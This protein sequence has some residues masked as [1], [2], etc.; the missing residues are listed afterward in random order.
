MCAGSSPSVPRTVICASLTGRELAPPA[1]R[2][3]AAPSGPP[4]ACAARRR[5][6]PCRRRRRAAPRARGPTSC[7]LRAVDLALQRAEHEVRGVDALLG[8]VVQLPRDPL[9]L[10][11]H[12][13]ALGAQA[14]VAQALEHVRR[15]RQRQHD[16]E[17]DHEVRGDRLQPDRALQRVRVQLG[18]DRDAEV[19]QRERQAPT[20]RAA[21]RLAGRRQDQRGEHED[22]ERA[23]PV[24]GRRDERERERAVDEPRRRRELQARHRR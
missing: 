23:A 7:D 16:D 3:S 6:C 22:V 4:A 11:L 9:A 15:V 5:S 10:A 1:A 18:V 17:R 24:L 19:G 2:A 21:K 14:L 8:G 20:E 12:R 13:Q